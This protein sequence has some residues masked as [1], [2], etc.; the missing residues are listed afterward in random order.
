VPKRETSWRGDSSAEEQGGQGR[1]NVYGALRRGDLAAAVMT[2]RAQR[3]V[4][5]VVSGV[6][7]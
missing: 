2:R 6:P 1:G 7:A 3:D 4:D 5:R